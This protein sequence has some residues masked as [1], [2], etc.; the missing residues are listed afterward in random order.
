MKKTIVIYKSKYGSAK[1]YAEWIGE[2][3]SCPVKELKTMDGSELSDYSTVIYGGGVHAGGIEGFDSFKKWLKPILADAYY[4]AHDGRLEFRTESY[5][6]EKKIIIFAVGINV[7]SFDARAQLRDV[8]FDKKWLRPLTCY[9]FEGRYNPREIKG[10]DKFIMRFV[11]K[12]LKDKGLNMK[13]EERTLLERIEGGCDLVD[14]SMIMP[15]VGEVL[16]G[17]AFRTEAEADNI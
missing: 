9:F 14:R 5:R 15:L 6:P 2:E 7:T 11:K 17:Q 10:I 16:N 4:E 3:L 1:R 8:N 12:M 13:P